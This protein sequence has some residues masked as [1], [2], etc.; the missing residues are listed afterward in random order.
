VS[1]SA[2]RRAQE[3]QDLR[4]RILAAA[5]DILVDE[6]MAGLSVRKLAARIGHTTGTVYHHFEGKDEILS[7]LI[8][9]GRSAI[10]QVISPLTDPGDPREVLRDN[11]LGYTRL[12]L[13]EKSLFRVL[14]LEAGADRTPMLDAVPAAGTPLASLVTFLAHQSAIGRIRAVD[15][16]L[17]ARLIWTAW[18][19]LLTRLVREGVNAPEKIDFYARELFDVLWRGLENRSA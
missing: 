8:Q 6:G 16:D 7:S 2:D 9:W 5:R 18:S 3:A 14:F 12:M 10:A 17:T 4:E 19:G 15:P 11:L 1:L 13:G